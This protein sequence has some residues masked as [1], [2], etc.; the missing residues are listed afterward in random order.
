MSSC[1]AA[2][3]PSFPFE[4]N[5]G[6]STDQS[7]SSEANSG[8]ASQ[9]MPRLLWIPMTHYRVP[10]NPSVDL[11]PSHMNPVHTIFI[12][13][14]SSL[15]RLRL[16]RRIFQDTLLDVCTQYGQCWCHVH[17]LYARAVSPVNCLNS[18]N[19]SI[20]WTCVW[21]FCISLSENSNVGN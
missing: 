13:I 2:L 5:F 7:P 15:L 19:C 4:W 21:A 17:V 3:R 20:T 6:N 12:L 11:I 14:C 1:S 9:E 18:H 8:A 16:L 10:Q